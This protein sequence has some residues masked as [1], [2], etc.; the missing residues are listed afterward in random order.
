MISHRLLR[1]KTNKFH[2]HFFCSLTNIK[3]VLITDNNVHEVEDKLLKVYRMY[4]DLV[5][6]KWNYTSG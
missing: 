3:F 4:S 2:I 5:R 6:N 1:V